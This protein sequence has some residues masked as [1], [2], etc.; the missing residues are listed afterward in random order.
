MIDIIQSPSLISFAGNPVCFEACSDNYLVST[1][2]RAYF[3]LVVSGIDQTEGHGFQLKFCGK[4]LVFR[5][6]GFTGYDGLLF[7]VA[8]PGSS[9]NDFAANIYQCFAENYDIQKY[10]TVSL[11]A[12]AVGS[13]KIILQA[14]EPG[15][16][17]SVA[18]SGITVNGVSQGMNTSGTDEIYRDYFGILCLIR[19]AQG[20]A[21]GEDIK[22]ADFIGSAKFDISDYL[23]SKFANW[24]LPRFEFPELPGNIK[25]HGWDFLL[26][27]RVSFAESIAGQVKGLLSDR[28]NYVLAGGLSR[29]LLTSLNENNQEYFTIEENRQKFLSWLPTTKYSRS[30]VIEKLFFLFQDNPTSI[31]YRMAVIVTFSDGTTKLINASPLTVFPAYTVVEFKVGFD[32][33]N[34]VN[35][36]PGKTVRSWEI[37]LLDD[38]DDHLSESRVFLNDT[39]VLENE[40]IFFYRNSF[41]A[42]DTVRFTGKGEANL[43]YER[44][45]GL[46]IKEERYS[47]CNAPSKQFTAQETESFKANSGWIS[48]Q[49]KNCLRELLLSREIYEQ[50]GKEFFPVMVKSAKITPFLK[51][52]EY[53]YNLEIEYERSYQNAY[54]SVHVPESPAIPVVLPQPLTWDNI[55]VSFDNMEL[56]FDLVEY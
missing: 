29:E 41:S 47:Y 43:E 10:F 23:L 37:V 53:L 4:T 50:I 34:L 36:Q 35:A 24:E 38:N 46:T 19:D 11:D 55:E 56:T 31:Q 27:Y 17:Y 48:L 52:G 28:W 42:Y 1:G 40:K 16:Q 21:I 30:G 12:P 20:S 9:F 13:R 22:P 15:E 8:F 6:S 33:L 2:S 3:E 51:S 32:H 25:S 26:K 7:E 44:Q 49:E 45:F 14:R 39:R 18:L 54:F 5:S